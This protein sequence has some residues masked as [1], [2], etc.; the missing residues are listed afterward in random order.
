M[1]LIDEGRAGGDSPL[2]YLV[3]EFVEGHAFPGRD[4]PCRWEDIEQTAQHFVNPGKLSEG[5]LN[6]VEAAIR[7]YDPCLSCSTHA[8]GQMPL[9][10]AVLP[11]SMS[12]FTFYLMQRGGLGKEFAT[13]R[14]N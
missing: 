10:I 5:M 1:R 6:R 12:F 3:T 13:L 14:N 2:E 9:D 7:C 4:A 8:L 11:A